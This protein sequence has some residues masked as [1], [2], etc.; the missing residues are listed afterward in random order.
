M[1]GHMFDMACPAVAVPVLDADQRA[2]GLDTIGGGGGG[3]GG[4][5]H[6]RGNLG[7][8]KKGHHACLR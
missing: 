7:A 4:G 6:S 8:G 1:L 2:L 5:H 3:G